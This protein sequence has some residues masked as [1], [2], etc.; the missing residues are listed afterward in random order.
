M[1]ERKYYK[2]NETRVSALSTQV[3]SNDHSGHKS[4]PGM[5]VYGNDNEFRLGGQCLSVMFLLSLPEQTTFKDFNIDPS[6]PSR[7]R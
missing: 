3:S 2:N 6:P 1:R 4:T 5:Y 7:P